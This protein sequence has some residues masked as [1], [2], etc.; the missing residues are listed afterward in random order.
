MWTLV[1]AATAFVSVVFLILTSN[2]FSFLQLI[3]NKIPKQMFL[4]S[5]TV[6][7]RELNLIVAL[8]V[9]AKKNKREREQTVSEGP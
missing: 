5:F 2:F 7:I 1:A 8:F 3:D 9:F 6:E 4:D